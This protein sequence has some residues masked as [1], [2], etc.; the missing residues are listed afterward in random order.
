MEIITED[1]WKK[2]GYLVRNFLPQEGIE[3]VRYK[4]Y[5][6]SAGWDTIGVGHK[7]TEQE[8]LSGKIILYPGN[9]PVE[10]LWS[11]KVSHSQ[12]MGLLDQDLQPIIRRTPPG[13]ICSR[14][15]APL[16]PSQFAALASFLFNVGPTR[17]TEASCTLLR[18]L[19]QGRYSDVPL[20]LMRWNKIRDQGKT[21]ISPGLAN[22]R[23]KEVL[24][25]NGEWFP[26]AYWA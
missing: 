2:A 22:R 13:Y 26:P 8:G 17:F 14:V 16:Q 19:N 4:V 10:I 11:Q 12:V 7:I 21:V 23:A 9:N 6:D 5:K 3:G 20:Q 24:L 18:R 25:W 1:D 15:K